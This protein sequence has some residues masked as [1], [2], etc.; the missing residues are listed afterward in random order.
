M[1]LDTAP[2]DIADYF[3][4]VRA[5]SEAL[6]EPLEVEDYG[7]QS[8][9]DTSPAKWHLAHTTWFY[10]QLVLW[11]FA[12][13]YKVYH[14]EFAAIFNSYYESLGTLFTRAERGVLSRPTVAEVY[15]YRAYVDGAMA[16]LL[17]D[18]MHPDRA[19]IISRTILGLN[20]EQQHQEL[21]LTDIK[22]AFYKNPLKPAYKVAEP[23]APTGT[24]GK[25]GWLAFT[26]GVQ[27]IGFEGP[28][29]AYD[30]ETP[31]HKVYMD[32]YALAD[33][34]VTNGEY[35]EFIE[36]GGY[37]DPDL[38][39]S[40][41]W[42]LLGQEG[43]HAPLYWQKTED[44]WTAMTLCGMQPLDTAAPVC[45][46]S[47]YEAAA[48]ARWRGRRLPTE[49]EWEH[50]VATELGRGNLYSP[51]SLAPQP[52]AGGSRQFFGDVWEWTASPYTEYPGYHRQSGPFGEYNGKFMSSQM[53][54]R[55][56]SCLTPADHIRPTYRNFF[57]PH[58]RWQ[59]SGIRLAEDR[60]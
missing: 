19:E 4:R 25:E 29:F 23:A 41:A 9:P 44:G 54:L 11:P 12:K 58:I 35:L 37:R 43:W 15:N 52:A 17:A 50:A 13:G 27:Q 14:P 20:H 34:L 46:V 22:H 38:W 39:L 49:A 55:G 30:N 36:A 33:R 7:L 3:S 40:D 57:Y 5:H 6:C 28:G 1:P 59:Y 53:V 47:F 8:M 21:L 2:S 48:Y 56:G 42:A 60:K 18:A 32:A 45:H 24:P 10:E 16:A 26:A 31:R 51:D